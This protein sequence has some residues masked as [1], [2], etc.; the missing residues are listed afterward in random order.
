MRPLNRQRGVA[1]MVVLMVVA[2]VSVLATEMGRRLQLQI[3]RTV[4]IKDSNQAYWY[5]V[6]AEAFARKSL[7][8]LM[9][10]DSDKISVDQ[11]WAQEFVFPLENGGLKARLEDMRSCFNLNALREKP[12]DNNAQQTTPAMQSFHDMLLATNLDIDSYTAE[13]V[14]DSLADWLDADDR[15]RPYGAEDSEYES[16]ENPYLAA[17]GL[18]SAQSELRLVNGVSP[19]WINAILPLVCVVPNDDTMQININTLTPERAP[20]LAGATGLTLDQATN[21]I[22]TRPQNGW[23]EA[24]DF[25]NEPVIQALNLDNTRRDWFTV[26]TEYFMLHTKTRYNNATFTM[27]TVFK[28]TASGQVSVLRRE[29]K[30]VD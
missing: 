30:E 21:L 8:A 24:G 5:A 16:R 7:A 23:A 3:Q 28:A 18:M 13:T 20:L 11:V 1:L 14:R 9:K 29:F 10:N 15:M 12:D 27:T 2:L 4:N 19:A 17:N 22:S 25:L 6:G 26:T